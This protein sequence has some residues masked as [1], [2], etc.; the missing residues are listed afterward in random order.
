MLLCRLLLGQKAP[1]PEKVKERKAPPRA[2]RKTLLALKADVRTCEDRVEK[3]AEML[4]KIDARLAQPEIY[5]GPAEKLEALQKKRAEILDAQERA[6]GLWME[7]Q[8]R[9]EEAGG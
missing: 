2:D 9:L 8:E 5:T 4:G 1:P 6:E 7:A 3:I